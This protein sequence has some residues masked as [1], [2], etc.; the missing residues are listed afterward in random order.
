M[1]KK[2][3]LFVVPMHITWASFIEPNYYNVGIKKQDGFSYNPPRT[4]LPLGPLSM[5]AYLKKFIDIDVK[6]IDFNAEVNALESIPFSNFKEICISFFDKIKDFNPDFIGV[7]S[8]FSPS[9]ANFMDAG[10]AAKEIWPDSLVLGGGNIP[11]N[12]YE[13]I[14]KDKG[15]TYFDGLCFGEGEK[16]LLSV[17]SSSDPKLELST[18]KSWITKE[19][20]L[21]NNLFVPKHDFIEDLDEIPFFDYDLCDIDKHHSNQVVASYH[22]LDKSRGFHIM[23]SR[24]CPYLCTF[25]ASHR[26]HGRSMRYHSI[27]RFKE[28]CIILKE[29]YAAET[30]IFQDDHLMGDTGRVYKI[31]DIIGELGLQSVYQNGLTLY[32]LDRPML[33]AFW[34]AGV[35]HLVLPVESGS[36]KVLKS[37]MKKPLKMRISYRV[38]KDCRDLGIYTNTNILIGMP[39]ETKSDLE[40]ARENLKAVVSNWFNIACASPIVGSEMHDIAKEKG[41]IKIDTLGSDY[42]TAVINTEDF[43]SDF[44]QDYQYFMNL[45][46]NFVSNQDIKLERWDWAIRGFKNVLRLRHDHAFAHYFISK[47]YS[48]IGDEKNSNFHDSQYYEIVKKENW[49][50]WAYIFG[51]PGIEGLNLTDECLGL[52]KDVL[53]NNI[54]TISAEV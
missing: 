31:L 53:R 36:E 2:S 11:T 41:Y 22:N 7:S 20:V 54:N 19:K 37:Q 9:F 51:L 39:G 23:T 12:S 25:C 4:D 6:L 27:S 1:K 35:R 15:C 43:S 47:A 44:I 34:N 18:N 24:G 46:L 50:R 13:E 30:V 49:S 17:I 21:S 29:Q 8:L 26:T 52:L 14:Y 45:D 38:A 3:L 40:E 28:D 32:A 33:E 10:L 42:R 48:A 5:S 16:P